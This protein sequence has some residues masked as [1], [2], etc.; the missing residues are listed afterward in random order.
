MNLGART[1]GHATLGIRVI[2]KDGKIEDYGLV[3]S[4]RRTDRIMIA[5]RR[6]IRRVT[7]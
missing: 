3:S 1:K 5:I 7:G 6:F 4:T 2:R